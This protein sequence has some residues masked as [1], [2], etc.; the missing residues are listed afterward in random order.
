MSTKP[1]ELDKHA[2]C[3]DWNDDAFS[4]AFTAPTYQIARCGFRSN[5][6]MAEFDRPPSN[7][8]PICLAL[9]TEEFYEPAD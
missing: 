4:H 6:K 8:C 5:R 1:K 7:A 9:W 3:D 2:D